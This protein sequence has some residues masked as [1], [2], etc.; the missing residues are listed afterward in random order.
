MTDTG[1]E[2]A[3]GLGDI[4]TG[5]DNLNPMGWCI[6]N[7]YLAKICNRCCKARRALNGRQR[8]WFN[9]IKNIEINWAEILWQDIDQ[10]IRQITQRAGPIQH[11][12]EYAA[13]G[14]V[15]NKAHQE[16]I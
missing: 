6:T 15:T 13:R 2:W 9:G 5:A 3:S 16:D 4:S 7:I 14:I 8:I 12:W 10:H 11:T 1:E